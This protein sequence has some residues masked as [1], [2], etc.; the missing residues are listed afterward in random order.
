[1]LRA[2]MRIE[3][4]DRAK[5]FIAEHGRNI[6]IWSDEAGFDHTTTQPPNAE[7]EFVPFEADGFT[8]HQ[9][10]GIVSPDY[11]EIEFHHL[12]HQHVTATWDG[13][14]YGVPGLFGLA[15]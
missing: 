11:W 2:D 10:A 7:T 15:P 8:L 9:E 13:G 14:T 3:A 12:P 5:E 6:Y 4:S 1:M